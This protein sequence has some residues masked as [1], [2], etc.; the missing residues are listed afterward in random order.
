MAVISL[1]I[2]YILISLMPNLYLIGHTTGREMLLAE[3]LSWLFLLVIVTVKV[4]KKIPQKR[5]QRLSFGVD[6][7]TLFLLT[8]VTNIAIFSAAWATDY[9]DN[10]KSRIIFALITIISELFVFWNGIIRVYVNS[11]QAGVPLKILGVFC[12]FIPIVNLII[13]FKLIAV[14]RA[15]IKYETEFENKQLSRAGKEVCKT[16]YPVLLVHGVFF[17]DTKLLNYWGRIPEALKR[18][19]A[20]IFYGK[21]QSAL[22]VKESAAELNE[23]IKEVLSE[24]GAEKVNIIAHS[25]GGLD[26]RYA[27]AKYGAGQYVA[28]LTTVNTPHRGCIF[29]DYLFSVISEGVRMKMA[30]AYNA[31]AKKVGDTS[32][33]FISAVTDLSHSACEVLN[34]EIEDSP[35]VYYQSVGSMSRNSR[36]GR[37]PMNVSYPL[38]KAKDGDNDGLVSVES[39]KWGENFRLIK[40]NGNR[41]VTH[42]D[43]IDLNR[44][45]IP[46]FNVRD[47]YVELVSDLKNKGF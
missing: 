30:S 44:E 10:A 27:I 39:M 18:N 21:Q 11:K 33:D 41:G 1:F 28:S 16:K 15:E 45:N 26:T 17:R 29:V 3:V 25:K 34:K 40:V 37:F 36:S 19:G 9:L 6:L 24:T 2:E 22:S 46:D 14:S 47:F 12:G 32:P 23:R 43:V 5:M 42:A 38:V 4:K 7:L 35:E 31:G 13:L 20:V 8:T